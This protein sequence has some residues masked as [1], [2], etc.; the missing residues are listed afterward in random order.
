MSR[1]PSARGGALVRRPPPP[2][3]RST[4]FGSHSD[5]PSAARTTDLDDS[6][7]CP[8]RSRMAGRVPELG[9]GVVLRVGNARGV[10]QAGLDVRERAGFRRALGVGVGPVLGGLR[11]LA[12]GHDGCVEVGVERVFKSPLHEH[13]L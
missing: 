7:G 6:G 8:I 1:L 9:D 12:V 2:R 11:D 13:E 10:E 4:W 3:I 5:L